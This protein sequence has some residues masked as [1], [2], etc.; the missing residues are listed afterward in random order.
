M[1]IWGSTL[2]CDSSL[3]ANSSFSLNVILFF[4][5]FLFSVLVVSK[6]AP[7]SIIPSSSKP[8][9]KSQSKEDSEEIST[10]LTFS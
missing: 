6:I 3:K 9:P 10:S 8:L 5:K 2:V 4:S 7:S 1:L